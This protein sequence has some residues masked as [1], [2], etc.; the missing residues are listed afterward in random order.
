VGA[1]QPLAGYPQP[2]GIKKEEVFDH[3][4]PTSYTQVT[5]GATPT[6]GDVIN[7]TDLGFGGFDR[8]EGGTDATAQWSVIAIPVNGGSGN[9]LKS[10]ILKW[11]ALVTAT[12]GGQAQTAGSEAAATTNLTTFFVRMRATIV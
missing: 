7:A 10:Y 6:G 1:N 9:A 3:A 12:L 5:A 2:L 8:V 11:T 4:G